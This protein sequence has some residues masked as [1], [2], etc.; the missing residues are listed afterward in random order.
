MLLRLLLFK[1]FGLGEDS[2]EVVYHLST[3]IDR[4][5]G[6]PEILCVLFNL[7]EISLLA[8]LLGNLLL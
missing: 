7:F 6:L 4:R 2:S 8:L 1:F 5:L 3:Q